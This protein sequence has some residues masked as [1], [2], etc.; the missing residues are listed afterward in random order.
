[1]NSKEKYLN[2]ITGLLERI[3]KDENRAQIKR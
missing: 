3:A 1:M 2:L